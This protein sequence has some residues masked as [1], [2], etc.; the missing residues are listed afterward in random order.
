MDNLRVHLAVYHPTG[1]WL[2]DFN[3]GWFQEYAR[4]SRE[5]PAQSH[6]TLEFIEDVSLSKNVL[7]S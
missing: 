1:L 3:K 2:V 5:T 6:Q 4:I 7:Q